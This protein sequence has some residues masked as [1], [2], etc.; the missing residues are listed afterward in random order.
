L[1]FNP[2]LESFEEYKPSNTNINKGFIDLSKNENPFDLS[3]DLKKIF[4]QKITE[5]NI[6]RYPELTADNIRQKI[7]TFLN[8]YFSRYNIDLD[9][10]NIV[11][12]NGSDEMISYLVK[13]FSG[14]EVIVCP[15]TFEM[16][17]F[18]SLLNGFS[19]KKIPLNTNYEIKDIDKAVDDQTGMIFICSPNNPTGN[20]Q[21]QK[22]IVKALNTGTPVIV[23]EAYADFSKTSKIQYLKD[24]PNLII[25]KTF[26]KAFGLAGIRAG[27]LIANEEI[28]KQIMKIKSP[29]SF[30]VLTEK[31]VET[32]IENYNLILEKIDYIIE[33]R[34]KLS[35]E[36]G[37]VALKSDANFILLDFDKIEG[38][39]AKAVYNYFLENKMLLRKYSGT[40][41]NKIRVTVGTKEEN[42]KFLS[43]FK[44]LTSNYDK[45]IKSYEH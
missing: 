33:E 21:P 8:S 32:I 23:D 29:Y 41:E 2:I 31:M 22:E 17:E 9:M 3:L 18:Y 6:N 15:P 24:Y 4:F 11:V 26:S 13:I 37:R 10:N 7:A 35:K 1:K 30:N 42:Q 19:V 34:N 38:I 28:V 25:L 43:L 5:T 36:L 40:L 16:Y 27:I 20:L 45:Q 39:T 14:N 12:G 44:E